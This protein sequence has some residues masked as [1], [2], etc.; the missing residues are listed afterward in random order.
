MSGTARYVVIITQECPEC[1]GKGHL[2]PEIWQEY[3]EWL[4]NN[5]WKTLE[6]PSWLERANWWNRRHFCA[7]WAPPEECHPGRL[8]AAPP[9]TSKCPACDGHGQQ[10][11]EVD[12]R[13]ALNAL[14]VYPDVGDPR[15]TK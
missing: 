4:R 9:E 15:Q 1:L 6:Y 13:E 3:L 10:R 7:P 14:G 8:D 5:H 12:L 2:Q 11:C